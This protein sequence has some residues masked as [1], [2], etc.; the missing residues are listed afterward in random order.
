MLQKSHHIL[1]L[2]FKMVIVERTSQSV[3]RLLQSKSTLTTELK[4]YL[5]KPMN[6]ANKAPLINQ[7][8]IL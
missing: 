6:K 5:D 4:R 3:K 2:L 7:L 1:I 8:Q